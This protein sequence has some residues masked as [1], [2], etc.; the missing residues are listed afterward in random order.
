MEFLPGHWSD[1]LLALLQAGAAV[2]ARDKDGTTPLHLSAIMGQK[3]ALLALLQAVAAVDARDKDGKTPL[4]LSAFNG[5]KDALL[6]LLQAGAA[7]DAKDNEGS[8]ALDIAKGSTALDIVRWSDNGLEY[9][10][11][12]DRHVPGRLAA[13]KLR[14]RTG[15]ELL[16]GCRRW[17]LNIPRNTLVVRRCPRP[18]SRLLRL[19]PAFSGHAAPRCCS[20]AP[21]SPAAPSPMHWKP[22]HLLQ[23]LPE[24]ITHTRTQPQR[25]RVCV[26]AT[27]F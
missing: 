17:T 21:C 20:K 10:L 27:E 19:S 23:L 12:H 1:A 8:T 18:R 26:R 11:Q 24:G 13:L 16:D 22:P 3:D 14:C 9:N 2:D 15:C 7:V 25:E 5:H 6:A 4:H